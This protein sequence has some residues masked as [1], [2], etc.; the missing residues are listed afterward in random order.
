MAS[1]K[2][3]FKI[4]SLT[5]RERRQIINPDGLINPDGD[6]WAMEIR[7]QQSGSKVMIWGGMTR[8]KFAGSFV[9]LKN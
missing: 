4:P 5:P 8:N 6:N 9:Y 7:R 3:M 2:S 1:V